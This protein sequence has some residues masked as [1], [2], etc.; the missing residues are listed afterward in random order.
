MGSVVPLAMKDL[1]TAKICTC[2]NSGVLILQ[3]AHPSFW[4][5]MPGWAALI[6]FIV[7]LFWLGVMEGLQVK[8]LT[9]QCSNNLAIGVVWSKS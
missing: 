6:I 1:C 4:D 9:L 8:V 2:C 3:T 5:V 7:I